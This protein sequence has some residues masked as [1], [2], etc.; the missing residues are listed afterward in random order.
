MYYY[1]CK[2]EFEIEVGGLFAKHQ[3]EF[4]KIDIYRQIEMNLDR[5]TEYV[6]KELRLNFI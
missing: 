1:W 6:N 5:I 3:K 4:E 2:S